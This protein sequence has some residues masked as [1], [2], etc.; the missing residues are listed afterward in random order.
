[1]SDLAI[2]IRGADKIHSRGVQTGAGKVKPTTDWT[3]AFVLRFVRQVKILPQGV[4]RL[5]TFPGRA[6]ARGPLAVAAPASY[7]PDSTLGRQQGGGD[8]SDAAL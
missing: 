1:M 6:A 4:G 7:T 5:A 8:R 2:E 3:K